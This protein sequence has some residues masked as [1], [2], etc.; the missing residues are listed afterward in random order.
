MTSLTTGIT[1]FGSETLQYVGVAAGR[2]EYRIYTD[3]QGW[4]VRGDFSAETPRG[5][6]AHEIR[7]ALES[8]GGAFV[9][10]L[11]GKLEKWEL[12]ERVGV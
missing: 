8:G 1:V 4:Y 10:F 12:K 7:N 5:K 2:L 11:A 9:E 6:H 3:R